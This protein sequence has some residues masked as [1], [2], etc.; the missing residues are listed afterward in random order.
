[1]MFALMGEE[2][3]GAKVGF[4]GVP[5]LMKVSMTLE[6]P[7]ATRISVRPSLLMSAVA[8]FCGEVEVWREKVGEFGKVPAGL[9]WV[10]RSWFW[11]WEV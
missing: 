7:V 3:F 11:V 10:K 6:E 1:M 5:V 4:S 2:I 8:I 9:P